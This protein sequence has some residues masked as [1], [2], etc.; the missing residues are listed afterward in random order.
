VQGIGHN[1]WVDSQSGF[2]IQE[3]QALILYLL[4]YEPGS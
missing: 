4:S 1:Y 3:Q 2:S